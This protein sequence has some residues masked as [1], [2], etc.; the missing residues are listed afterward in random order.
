VSCIS[1]IDV[2]AAG[3]TVGRLKLQHGQ[4]SRAIVTSLSAS[5]CMLHSAY[6]WF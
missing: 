5:N 2:S 1:Q 3:C 6:S 4:E